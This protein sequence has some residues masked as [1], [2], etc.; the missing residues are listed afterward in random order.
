MFEYAGLFVVVVDHFAGTLCL[1]VLVV[2]TGDCTHFVGVCKI[3]ILS[4]CIFPYFLF[5]HIHNV[6]I[7]LIISTP[8][9]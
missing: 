4:D 7:L 9:Y 2:A 5:H 6:L 3:S 1:G 8:K